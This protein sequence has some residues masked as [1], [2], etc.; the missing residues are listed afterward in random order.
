MGK[1]KGGYYIKARKIQNSKIMRQ[2]PHVREIWDWILKEANH[3]DVE[4]GGFKL[5]RGQLFR[6]YMDIR[7]GLSWNVGW[8][9]M[10]YNENQTKKAMKF[11]RDTLMIDTKKEP[12]G[13]LITICNYDIYQNPKNYERTDE[14]TDERTIEEPLKNQPVPTITRTIEKEKNI[15]SSNFDDIWQMYPNKIGESKALL[16]FKKSVKSEQDVSDIKT[17]LKNYKN[18]LEKN[19]W[20]KPQDGSTWFNNW[21]DWIDFEEP[22]KEETEQRRSVTMVPGL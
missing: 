21:K 8:R 4:Y 15:Y 13:V 19:N 16:S 14:R 18:H 9:K 1:I 5:K 22:K 11:L 20:K 17:A 7:E 6:T 2:P 10:M 3:K 12:G